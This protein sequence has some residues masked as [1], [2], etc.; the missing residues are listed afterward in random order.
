MR[1]DPVTL[2]VLRYSLQ[3]IAEEM[4]VCIRRTSYSTNIKARADYSCALFDRSKRAIVQALHNPAHLGAMYLVVPRALELYGTE[5]LEEG[6]VILINDPYSGGTHLPDCVVISP[7]F[8][9][10]EITGYVANLAHHVD[11]GGMTPGSTPGVSTEIYQEG[12]IIP[13]VKLVKKGKIDNDILRLIVRNT[14][15]P[16]ENAGDFRAQIAG[17][18][19]GDNRL[20]SL[21]AKYGL[22]VVLDCMEDL[23]NYSERRMRSEIEKFPEGTYSAEDYLDDDGVTGKPVKIAVD[24]TIKGPSATVDFS[25]SDKQRKGNVNTVLSRSTSKA[26]YVMKCLADPEN[27]IPINR[28]AFRP[29][30]VIAPEGTV[31]NA[32][33]PAACVGGSETDYRIIDSMILALSKAIPDRVM[34]AAKGSVTNVSFGGIDPRTRRVYAFYESVGGGYGARPMKD[35]LDGVQIHC[36][37]TKN[38]PIEELEANWPVLVERYELVQD[39]DGAGKFR[40]GL[41]IRR[42][43]KFVEHE[44][45]FSVLTDRGKF[46][47][48][49]LFGGLPGRTH[50]TIVNPDSSS[51]N[52]LSTKA[53]VTLEPNSV[54]SVQTAGGGGYGN[55]RQRDHSAVMADLRDGKISI[56]KA[57]AV[58]G[59]EA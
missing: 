47:P 37:N 18:K 13:P 14:R 4:G 5:N 8:T 52:E 40:G 16:T 25:R 22:N 2:E 20:Q 26:Y 51:P 29:I 9:E 50:K 33:H 7:S 27:D 32:S 59:L 6:D 55:P 45:V 34:A 19:L 54:V 15:A 21:V 38:T 49:G 56:E 1:T 31:V 57:R 36:A 23:L 12:I 39:S 42:D 58:Y 46:S 17:A 28:G 44:A 35:G 53:T 3:A 30:D 10:S 43:F 24:I 41:G 11:V 48:Y